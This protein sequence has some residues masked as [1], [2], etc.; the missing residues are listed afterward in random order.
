MR[1]KDHSKMTASQFAHL[2]G[3]LSHKYTDVA[4]LLERSP[5]TISQYINGRLP[6][7]K[8]VERDILTAIEER[9]RLLDK[10]ITADKASRVMTDMELMDRNRELREE[11]ADKPKLPRLTRRDL[12]TNERQRTYPTYRM[13][14]EKMATYLAALNK[15]AAHIRAALSQAGDERSLKQYTLELHEIKAMASFARGAI[16]KGAPY[17]VCIT[18]AEWNVAS[19][20]LRHLYQTD[21]SNI[22]YALYEHWRIHKGTGYPVKRTQLVLIAE[23]DKQT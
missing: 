9:K 21:Q 20:A 18:H 13:S 6:I 14:A 15:W 23:K 19:S 5:S 7:T 1:K 16:E 3:L 11:A 8:Q 12:I 17:D 2:A 22:A 4:R 10:L